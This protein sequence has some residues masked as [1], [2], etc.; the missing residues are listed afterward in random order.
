[1]ALHVYICVLGYVIKLSSVHSWLKNIACS[2]SDT[3]ITSTVIVVV[4]ETRVGERDQ[5]PLIDIPT[6][7]VYFSCGLGKFSSGC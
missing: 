7:L 3:P 5:I 1:M 2:T 6:D 4:K